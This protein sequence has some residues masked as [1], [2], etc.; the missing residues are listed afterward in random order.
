MLG[1]IPYNDTA[2]IYKTGAVDSWGLGTASET[3]VA[4]NCLIRE[5]QTSET[6][7]SE[8][9]K[10]IKLQYKVSFEGAVDVKIGDFI[11][12]NSKKFKVQGIN[13]IKDLAREVVSTVVS[14]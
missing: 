11:E 5:V 4:V 6:V 12:I 10:V 2:L 3:G 13:P 7:A 9:G 14:I 8:D 1:F